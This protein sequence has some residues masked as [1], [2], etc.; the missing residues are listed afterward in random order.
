MN[1]SI[2]PELANE[3]APDESRRS[4]LKGAALLGLGLAA[5]SLGAGGLI[6]KTAAA[7]AAANKPAATPKAVASPGDLAILNFA[8]TLEQ[9]EL[10]FYTQA[11]NADNRA[12]FLHG[13]LHEIAPVIRDNENQHVQSISAAISGL[14][15]VP[16]AA[17]AFRFPPEAFISPVTFARFAYTLEEIGVGAYLG[18]ISKISNPGLRRAAASIYGNETRHVA[19]LRHLGGYPIAPRYYEGPLT[20]A[21][22]QELIAPYMA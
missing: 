2:N 12:Q 19:L 3:T 22:V 18:A 15:G 9:L 11:V 13:R 6:T 16:A 21:K 8:L 20:V 10:S 5:G 17:P 7:Q 14:G 1:P 4:A